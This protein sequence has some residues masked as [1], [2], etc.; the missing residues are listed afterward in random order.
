MTSRRVRLAGHVAFISSLLLFL[1]G[2]QVLREALLSASKASSFASLQLIPTFCSSLPVVLFQVVC[3]PLFLVPWGFQSNS[4]LSIASCGGLPNVWP[5]QRQFL[6]FV[7][8]VIGASFVLCHNSSF[9]ILSSHLTFQIC[10]RHRLT[11]TR[12]ELLTCLVIFHVSRPM[13]HACLHSI[14]F[15]GDMI[16]G[17][18]F[19]QSNECYPCKEDRAQ[20]C[21]FVFCILFVQSYEALKSVTRFGMLLQEHLE[22]GTLQNNVMGWGLVTVVFFMR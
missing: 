20:W 2:T 8:C 18:V 3:L 13:W 9:E 5:I 4:C 10:R 7:C 17:E 14:Q 16:G 22:E 1:C 6:S 21:Y 11:N 12:S 19:D 15:L